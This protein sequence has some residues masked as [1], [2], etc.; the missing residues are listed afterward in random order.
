MFSTSKKN[1]SSCAV[2]KLRFFKILGGNMTGSIWIP[3]SYLTINMKVKKAHT[4]GTAR[5]CMIPTPNI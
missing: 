2:R 4:R 1:S 5:A 3:G